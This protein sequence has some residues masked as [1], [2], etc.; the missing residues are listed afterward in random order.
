MQ[1]WGNNLKTTT[2]LDDFRTV[3]RGLSAAYTSGDF[4]PNE[5]T[6]NLWYKA[7]HNI[8]Y[9]TLNKAA[10]AYMMTN[11]FPPT[12]ADIRR[13]AC[14]LVLPAD[15]IAA[16]EWSKLMRALGQ[17]GGA[18]CCRSLGDAPGC[19]AGNSRKLFRVYPVVKYADSRSYVSATADVY[20]ALRRKDKAKKISRPAAWTASGTNQEH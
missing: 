6:F 16:E 8:D 17:A 7:L 19:D 11:K 12:I 4:I 9:V 3:M 13:I 14:D 2:S 20:K 1:N 18:R 15:E 10:Q 5:Y